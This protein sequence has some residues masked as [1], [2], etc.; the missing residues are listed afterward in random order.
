MLTLTFLGIGAAFAKRNYQSNALLETWIN[1]PEED[2]APSDVVL[3]DFGTT[4]PLALHA[5]KDK[6]GFAYLDREGAINYPAIRRIVITH[7]H[8]DHVGGLEELAA[9]STHVYGGDE[10]PQLLGAT[11][12]LAKLWEHSLK[13]GLGAMGGR[14][15]TLEDYFH[16]TQISPQGMQ[17]FGPQDRYELEL[18]PTD[19]VRV[20]E[21]YD[22]PSFGLVLRD[23]PRGDHA[24]FSGDTRFDPEAMGEMMAGARIIFHEAQLEDC[25]DPVHALVSELRTLPE[26][27]RKKMHLYHVGDAWDEGRYAFVDQEF[28]GFARPAHRYVVFE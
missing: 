3:I 9:M 4:G 7:T 16:V 10:R 13:G 11:E 19:H 23:S 28:A 5:L 15:A 6:P 18:F 1:S 12:V 22:W 24:V 14:L 21:K 2:A 25:A 17:C 27:V 20:T 8:G 26:A